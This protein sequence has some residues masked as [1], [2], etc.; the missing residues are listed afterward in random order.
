MSPESKVDK[1]SAI[2]STGV[3]LT[4][5]IVWTSGLT[6]P[7]GMPKLAILT[8]TALILLGYFL[9]N[10]KALF[11][12]QKVAVITVV[13]FVV[14]MAF[15]A[16]VSSNPISRSFYGVEARRT[17]WLTYFSFG[18]IFL[19]ATLMRTAKSRKRIYSAFLF[20]GLF[21]LIY[22]LIVLIS[23]KDPIPW[24]NV[25][26][27]ILGTFGNPNFISAFLGLFAVALFAIFVDAK[28]KL[29]LRVLSAI[30]IL[31][32]V[33]EI[34]ETSS[35]QG[36]VVVVL[37]ISV[38][39][40]VYLKF[41]FKNNKLTVGYFLAL[42]VMALIGILGTLQ[43]GPLAALLYKDSVSF[44]G[45]Y[46]FAGMRMIQS[47]PLFGL[48]PD[49]YGNWY[50][51]FRDSSSIVRP[52]LETTANTAHNV[53]VDIGVN[54]GIP[55]LLAY[56]VLQAIA[57][58]KI[59]EILKTSEKFDSIFWSFAVVWF[60]YH[61][62]S[63][64]S[65]NQIGLA[66]WGWVLGGLIL[67][68]KTTSLDSELTAPSNG[69]SAQGKRVVATSDSGAG[70][71]FATIGGVLAIV[72]VFPPLSADHG[73]RVGLQAS[74]ANVLD[75]ALEKWPRESN[76]LIT[77][78]DIFARNKLN[79]FALKFARLAIQ[80]DPNNFES[81]RILSKTPGATVEEVQ[82][83]RQEMMRLDPLNP[84]LKGN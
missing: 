37:G 38:V 50:R 14:W 30:G 24:N 41:Q 73:W 42:G 43:K 48:G 59:I 16:L 58:K 31:I 49:S 62:Q 10:A 2:L 19:I 61:A 54:G 72:L 28:I 25:Y 18:V 64:I 81:W 13:L 66:I 56:L 69:K 6:E 70:V 1:S 83:A 4:T 39:L 57:L 5:L 36:L 27:T 84:E 79:D 74:D 17:G 34:I 63:V 32:A 7:V 3:A 71:V 33:Y 44:R 76:R 68:Y 82:K 75:Q 11:R 52:G 77:G 15:A 26:G 55:V 51:Q 29:P 40:G 9:P 53:F 23:K 65:I 8:T 45:E 20:C 47:S 21:N 12:E 80:D 22:S 35:I 46:W 78:S 60:C 67:S